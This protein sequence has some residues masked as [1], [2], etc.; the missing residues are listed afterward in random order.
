M[1]ALHDE[2]VGHGTLVVL[3]LL[4]TAL[5]ST[6][7]SLIYS[8]SGVDTRVPAVL[9]MWMVFTHMVSSGLCCGVQ[10][11][12]VAIL[13]MQRPIPH[14][15]EAQ[16]AVFLGVALG[17]TTLSASCVG[18]GANVC[19]LYFGAAALPRF[20]AV[21][22]A[23]WA[24]V[25]YVSSLG[26]QTDITRMGALTAAATMAWLPWLIESTAVS[27]CG[28]AWRVQVCGSV[29]VTL[30]ANATASTITANCDALSTGTWVMSVAALGGALMSWAPFSLV[31]LVGAI[32][33]GATTAGV[34][35]QQ[36]TDASAVILPPSAYFIALLALSLCSAVGDAWDLAATMRHYKQSHHRHRHHANY[37]HSS[38]TVARISG[39]TDAAAVTASRMFLQ[40]R[41]AQ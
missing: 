20:A 13:R 18:G 31:R 33:V 40:S 41:K 37:Y 15:A 30:N 35:V 2:L 16:S 8:V 32:L 7:Y 14:V 6:T 25:M 9:E 38:N 21:G 4:G 28:D 22:A 17:M 26:C 5:Y 10:V 1:S 24:W 29:R 12:L 36:T 23:T 34:W 39:P 27:T 3:S 11:V 19:A